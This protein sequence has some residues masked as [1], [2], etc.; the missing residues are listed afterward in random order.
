M[1]NEPYLSILEATGTDFTN[2]Y[3]SWLPH[4]FT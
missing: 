4:L 1:R 2:L 3:F